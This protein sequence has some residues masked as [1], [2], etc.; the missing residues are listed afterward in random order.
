MPPKKIASKNISLLKCP[1][2]NGDEIKVIGKP[3]ISVQTASFITGDYYIVKC[4]TCRF[5]FVSPDISLSKQQW[6]KL[7]GD[8]YFSEMPRW[9][10][11]KRSQDRKQRLDWLKGYSNHNIGKF[12]DIGSGEGYVLMDALKR[13]WDTHGIDI[14]D[15]RIES[16]KDKRI[17]FHK[18]NIFQAT[19]PN[20]YFDCIYM[21]SMLEHVL[22][23]LRHLDEIRRILRVGGTVYIGVPNEDCLFNNVKCFLYILSGRS[24][25][26]AYL[27][28]FKRPYHVIG[29]TT[30]SLLTV[31]RK[32]AFEIVSFRNFA[33]EYEW[34]KFKHFTK[35]FLVNFCLLP[36]H[37][38]AIPLRKRIY[39]DTI[40]RKKY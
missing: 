4:K 13:G 17:T 31:L 18:G 1:I 12:L 21:D 33:G 36:V 39:L 5:Y 28:P 7:Y 20:D 29:F 11:R 3:Q 9:W 38:V 22:D 19:F 2:C 6:E 30:K 27:A 32:S 26:S 34:R 40:I 24:N 25:L 37:L 8:E 35:P 14:Y 10:A 15:S 16:A 23:P